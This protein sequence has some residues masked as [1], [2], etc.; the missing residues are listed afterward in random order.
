MESCFV[1][2]AG[3]SDAVTRRLVVC[4]AG[5]LVGLLTPAHAQLVTPKTVPVRQDNQFAIFPSQNRGM[6]D[7]GIALD[8][9]LADPFSN[10][11]LTTMIRVGTV[12]TL[13]YTHGV[14]S[15][16]GGGTTLPVGGFATSGNWAG[17][18]LLAVQQ[19]NHAGGSTIRDRSA[20]NQYANALVARRLDNGLSIGASAY[21]AGLNAVDGV[22]LLYQGNDR[23]L[24]SGS[25]SDMRIG[26]MKEWEKK[27]IDA[28]LVHS[29]THMRQ[30]V[31][32]TD[33]IFVP[34]TGA[35]TTT[36]REDHNV[37]KTL[38]WGAQTHYVQEI[39][40]HGWKIGWVTTGNRL[41]H[42]KIPN[43]QIQ[44]IPRDP[45]TTWGFNLGVGA[46]RTVDGT[47]FGM[48]VVEEPIRSHTWGTTERD[49]A[50][51][52]GGVIRAGGRTVT[53]RFSFTNARI[54]LGVGHDF[55]SSDSINVYGV[56]LGL[57]AYSINYRLHQTN[58]V[59]QTERWQDE[60]WTEW[61]PSLGLSW[62]T[63]DLLLQ[64]TYRR[65]CGP[66]DCA[67]LGWFAGG[68]KIT[69]PPP[70][71]PGGVIAAPAGPLNIDG[72]TAH[73]HRLMMSVPIR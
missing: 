32:Y 28:V 11:A 42:P 49:T 50:I 56:Q 55:K 39:G 47:S 65:T 31:H 2:L 17:G 21:Y 9:T 70:T 8:D 25:L 43:Y 52:G 12:F 7:I 48:D 15:G 68:D 71:V 16:R 45:G 33:R 41:S 66:S 60:G 6:A 54:R 3:R 26:V 63:K 36:T 57:A 30:D 53:N 64:Y 62:R 73:V 20:A 40:D 61:T 13:P 38:I 59:Q 1:R 72:G 34:A 5:L 14:T 35:V 19:L 44:N 27:R 46:A 18:L 23:L 24:Q 22:D 29:R 4:T 51:V 69:V 37:D 67:G 58:H 10:P